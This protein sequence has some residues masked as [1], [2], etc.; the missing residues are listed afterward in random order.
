MP[1]APNTTTGDKDKYGIP[2]AGNNGLYIAKK[3]AGLNWALSWEEMIASVALGGWPK[4][5]WAEAAA[6][7]ASES[8]RNPFIYNTYKKGHFGLFQISRSAHADFF[9]PSGE[10]MTWVNPAENAREG[11]RIY[12]NEGWGAW[13][14]H[15]SGVYLTNLGQAKAA[16]AAFD[17]KAA[18]RTGTAYWQS[19][20]RMQTRQNILTAVSSGG[21][22]S[23]AAGDAIGPGVAAG[24]EG[25][26][27][28]V[29]A[30]GDAVTSTVG[31][32]AQVVTGFW[33]AITNPS[34]WMRLGYGALG[35]VLVGGG[36][37]LI[38]R[39]QPA[40]QRATKTVTR[41]ATKGVVQ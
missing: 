19:L 36:L 37:F 26:A 31:D 4:A 18:G 27:G 5:K 35:I 2:S 15:S 11:Y 23:G 40:V 17:K 24:A 25:A 21:G 39:N 38:V 8:S 7:A 33:G 30:A 28:G 12:Q 32:M 29:V 20:Y 22:L 3:W 10:G 16:V 13:E 34:L 14:A 6:T 1:L 41:V 9:A